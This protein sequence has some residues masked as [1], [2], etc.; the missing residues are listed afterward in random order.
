MPRKKVIF[1]EEEKKRR[2]AE[3]Q[4]RWREKHPEKVKNRVV[5]VVPAKVKQDGTWHKRNPEK[6]AAIQKK[7]AMK[8]RVKVLNSEEGVRGELMKLA[9]FKEAWEESRYAR[10]IANWAGEAVERFDCAK[11]AEVLRMQKTVM[12]A[13]RDALE[14]Y[15]ADACGRG[16][17]PISRLV[18]GWKGWIRTPKALD[19][20]GELFGIEPTDCS[21]LDWSTPTFTTLVAVKNF[22]GHDLTRIRIGDKWRGWKIVE[23]E[24][25][26]W[27]T[28]ERLGFTAFNNESTWGLALH[29]GAR[30]ECQFVREWKYP[31]DISRADLIALVEWINERMAGIPL[32]DEYAVD[33]LAVSVTA[34]I[35]EEDFQKVRGM[36]K[37]G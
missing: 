37:K 7:A 24:L 35:N 3:A 29:E 27:L 26:Q 2:N 33:P 16:D 12:K 20:L 15:W 8:R 6:A 9:W 1:T 36:L 18:M 14:F 28:R 19:K 10:G 4:K 21:D 17:R 34:E 31:C 23:R 13:K 5:K 25:H 32:V 30:L 22:F 11:L